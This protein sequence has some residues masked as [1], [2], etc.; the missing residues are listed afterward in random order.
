MAL[1]I[2]SSSR[3]AEP[4]DLTTMTFI[5]HPDVGPGSETSSHRQN[6]GPHEKS[7]KAKRTR[8]I[9]KRLLP[10]VDAFNWRDAEHPD[11]PTR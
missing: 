3:L 6:R 11:P 4:N 10:R 1:A 5:K 9:Y 8:T 2:Q 7:C